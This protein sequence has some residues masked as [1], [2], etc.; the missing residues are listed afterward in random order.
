MK[1]QCSSTGKNV[2][3]YLLPALKILRD[4]EMRDEKSFDE[5][6][7][8]LCLPKPSLESSGVKEDSAFVI[9]SSSALRL[10]L[11]Y[12]RCTIADV[13]VVSCPLCSDWGPESQYNVRGEQ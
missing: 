4:S 11:I 10:S 13:A 9:R 2:K 6:T 5:A 12:S 8:R 1:L 3:A 7:S